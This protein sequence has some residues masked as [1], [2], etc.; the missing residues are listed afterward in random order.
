MIDKRISYRFGGGYQGSS[1]SSGPAGGASSGGN[2][3]GN[4]GGNQTQQAARE[5]AAREQA[6]AQ[7]AMQQQIAQAE[8]QAAA[9][10]AEADRQQRVADQ[11]A[12]EKAAVQ[13]AAAKKALD[14]KDTGTWFDTHPATGES[15]MTPGFEDWYTDKRTI[16]DIPS[17]PETWQKPEI[18]PSYSY[19]DQSLGN[20]AKV[21]M[22]PYSYDSTQQAKAR[23][24]ADTQ[25]VEDPRETYISELAKGKDKENIV[26]DLGD[27]G[28]TA[29]AIEAAKKT[30]LRTQ[31]EKDEDW[32][33]KQDWD[34][35]KDLSEKGYDYRKIQDA[36]EKGLTQK[37]PTTS[38]RRKDLIDY[39]LKSIMPETG[40]EKSLLDRMKSFAPDA[41]G[42]KTGIMGTLG[43][44]FNPGKMMTNFALNKMGLSWLNPIIGI[45]SL[46]GF[47]NPLANI[48]TKF[49]GVPTKKEPII[50]NKGSDQGQ[51]KVQAQDNVIQANI[52]KFSPEQADMMNWKRKYSQLQEV[53]D[54]GV[55]QGRQLTLEEIKMLQQKSLDIQKLMDQYLVNPD[56]LG[57]ARGGIARLYG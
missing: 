25:K 18:K 50:D 36:V 13:K 57:L 27:A 16:K 39:G 44:Y 1:A 41:S 5:Q 33:K 4:T 24:A 55:Y 43:N 12:A 46:L 47:K 9:Q 23:T 40:L 8:A 45:A 51:D 22:N 7:R 48:G 56:D 11:A 29:A 35:V 28:E 26:H 19:T 38:T 34:L 49:T 37:A 14:L 21:H 17:M 20:V 53:I 32:E 52:R 30:D 6:T 3:G 10:R 31:K 42:T 2:Y 54:S 15:V